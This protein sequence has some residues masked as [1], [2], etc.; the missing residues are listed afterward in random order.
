MLTV[1]YAD[2]LVTVNFFITFLLLL[3]CA[4]LCKEQPKTARFVLASFIGGAYSLVLLFDK[5]AFAV[6]FFGKL[7][8]AGVIV[9]AAF[10]K[11]P[12]KLFLKNVAIFMFV[13]FVFLGLISGGWMLFKPPGVVINNSTVYFDVSAE[14]LLASAAFAYAATAIIIR[15]YNNRISKKEIYDISVEKDGREYRFFAFA[16]SGNN[17]KEPFTDS[18][19]I[20]VSADVFPDVECNRVIPVTTVGGEGVLY[21]F[22]PDKVTVQTSNGKS[23]LGNVYIAL[24]HNMKKGEYKGIINP[25]SVCEVKYASKN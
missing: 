19:V 10:G 5:L 15:I 23:L 21:A 14:V 17:L 2:V 9:F 1:V 8:A 13:N 16:D 11:R 22:K 6:S 20:V 25:N 7:A 4:K 12:F 18:P 24:S 3:A